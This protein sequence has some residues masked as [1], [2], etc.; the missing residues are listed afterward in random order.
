M[1][2][3]INIANYIFDSQMKL[4]KNVSIMQLLKLSF[5]SHGW[6][7]ALNDQPLFKDNIEAWPLGPV[8]VSI[9]KHFRHQG[10]DL[11]Q[12]CLDVINEEIDAKSLEV[13]DAVCKKYG[14]MSAYELS[15]LTHQENSPWTLTVKKTG[16]YST[17]T[18]DLI[19]DYY[20]SF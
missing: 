9:Y 12:K 20:K 5:L 16:L 4:N 1:Y 7:L 8:S 18:D 10:I 15:D 3:V 17:I 19:K 14:S 11:K 2:N 13:I 6:S